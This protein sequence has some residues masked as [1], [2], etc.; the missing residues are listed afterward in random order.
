VLSTCCLS[1]VLRHCVCSLGSKNLKFTLVPP[2]LGLGCVHAEVAPVTSTRSLVDSADLIVVGKVE[3][4]ATGAGKIELG[5]R[6]YEFAHA[7][8]STS[9]FP[10][11]GAGRL[12]H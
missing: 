9:A 7:I 3:R 10:E 4:V 11:I 1:P 5:G 12:L 8:P 6:D 2:L